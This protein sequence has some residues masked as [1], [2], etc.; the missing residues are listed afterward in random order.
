MAGFVRER[1][2]KERHKGSI[3]G[4]YLNASARG[5]GIGRK[6]LET[7]LERTVKCEGLEQIVL[8]VATTQAAASS[9]Y[10]SLGFVPFGREP[11]ALKV[12]D[13]YIDEEYMVLHLNRTME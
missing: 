11:R 8:S 4:V 5:K 1:G 3:W 7:L 6:L 10:R 12:G 9:L 13:C 2:L